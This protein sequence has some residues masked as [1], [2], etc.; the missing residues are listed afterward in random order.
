MQYAHKSLISSRDRQENGRRQN[1]WTTEG[2]GG[3]KKKEEI[4]ERERKG[5]KGE[6]VSLFFCLRLELKLNVPEFA[7]GQPRVRFPS[8]QSKIASPCLEHHA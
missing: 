5:V 2:K 1:R 8:I 4:F 6:G 7:K 3:E